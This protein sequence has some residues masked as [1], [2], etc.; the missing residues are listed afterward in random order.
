[1]YRNFHGI[2]VNKRLRRATNVRQN[3]TFPVVSCHN[4][5]S[6]NREMSRYDGRCQFNS[7][8][9]SRWLINTGNRI[10]WVS[11]FFSLRFMCRRLSL[12][13]HLY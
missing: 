13:S 9:V 6:K 1:M 2:S 5:R 4:D 8:P 10:K 7:N 11:G 12:F 3:L